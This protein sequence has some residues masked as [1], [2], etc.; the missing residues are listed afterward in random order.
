MLFRS[1]PTRASDKLKAQLASHIALDTEYEVAIVLF[2]L[3]NLL[4]GLQSDKMMEIIRTGLAT[5][6]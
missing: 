1:D 3:L 5:F 4:I 2:V 6:G